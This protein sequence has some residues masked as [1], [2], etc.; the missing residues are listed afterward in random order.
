VLAILIPWATVRRFIEWLASFLLFRVWSAHDTESLRGISKASNVPL[1]LLVALNVSLDSLMGC[2]SGG[3]MVT[4]KLRKGEDATATM[5]HFRTLDW[6][7][8]G[9]RSLLVVLE[10]VD[11][12]SADPNRVIKTSIT[13]AG[14][15]GVLTWVRY[16]ISLLV[17]LIFCEDD[18]HVFQGKCFNIAQSTSHTS[19]FCFNTPNSSTFGPLWLQTVDK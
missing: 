3:V 7:M 9:L 2:T 16:A 18:S 11:S 6:G 14:F 17:L 19:L 5:M 10:F 15:V 8:D 12:K 13:Y 4:P 1:Y